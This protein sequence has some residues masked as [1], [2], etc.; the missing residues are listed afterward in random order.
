MD[1]ESGELAE[2]HCVRSMHMQVRDRGTGMTLTESTKKLIPET[3]LYDNNADIHGI[4][5]RSIIL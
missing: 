4:G 5:N 2:R 3:R 1:G